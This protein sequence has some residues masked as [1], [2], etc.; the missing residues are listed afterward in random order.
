MNVAFYKK[1]IVRPDTDAE[2]AERILYAKASEQV[3]NEVR[4]NFP[5]VTAENFNAAD[6]FRNKRMQELLTKLRQA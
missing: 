5:T 2:I 6:S 1:R 3:R 4:A